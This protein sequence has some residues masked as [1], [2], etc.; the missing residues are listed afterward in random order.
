VAP[1][2]AGARLRLL[3][4]AVL[5]ST[6]GAGI[7]W[8]T[9]DAWQV[10]CFRSGVAALAVWLLVPAARRRWNWRVLV[11]AA[12]FALT[13]TLFVTANKLTTSANAIFLQS[14]APLWVLLAG[15]L[16]LHERATRE[17]LVFMAVVALGML[18]FFVGHDRPQATAPDPAR[19]NL[20][21]VVSGV[22]YAGVVLGLRWIGR[23]AEGPA[24]RRGNDDAVATVVAGN[25]LACLVALPM[26]LPAP[27]P[28]LTDALVILYLGAVQIG[29]AYLMMSTAMPHVPALEA[30]TILLVEPA[31]NPLWAWLVHGERPAALSIAGGAVIIL[32]AAGKAWWDARRQDR[33]GAAT[34]RAARG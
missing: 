25:V 26:A 7:K 2:R 9:L 17:D 22:G 27:A 30:S 1:T 31:L 19:G 23:D 24:G 15:P 29:L 5:F 8:T 12:A 11:V 20:L 32:S 3:G 34:V 14:T 18:L 28:H 21:A 6:G 16:L 4:T 33:R 13:L 10:S